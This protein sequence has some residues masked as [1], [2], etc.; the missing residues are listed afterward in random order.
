MPATAFATITTF[1]MILLSKT[2]VTL[3]G[4]V[5]IAVFNGDDSSHRYKNTQLKAFHV[6]NNPNFVRY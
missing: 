1:E 6:L 3:F 4:Q 5:I 2:S